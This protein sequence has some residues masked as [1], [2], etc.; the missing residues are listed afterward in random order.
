MKSLIAT[1]SKDY[2]TFLSSPDLSKFLI[3][4]KIMRFLI[5]SDIL[6]KH[7]YE[8]ALLHWQKPQTT[9]KPN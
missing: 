5:G 8:L 6:Y 9:R 1:D 4:N 2:R 7:Q 3:C